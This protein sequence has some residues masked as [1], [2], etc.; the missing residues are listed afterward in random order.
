MTT[1]TRTEQITV[2]DAPDTGPFTAHLALPAS[3]RGPGLVLIQEIFGVNRYIR[4]VADRLAALGYVVLAPDMF[5]R[6]EPGVA[7]DGTDEDA[8]VTA[9]GYA[10]RFDAAA[11]VVDLGAALDH[12]RV[13]PEC[14]G[15]VGVIGFCFGGTFAYLAAAHLDPAV[16]VSYYGSGV[17][18]ALDLLERVRGPILFHFGDEDPYL[19]NADVDRLREASAGMDNVEI[20]VQ[21]GAGHA[22]D[23]GFNPNFS[24]PTAAAAAW[25][26]TV[27]FLDEH[28]GGRP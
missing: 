26:R 24:D 21:A 25:E 3:G 10:G 19:P 4:D 12:L 14:D 7:I 6:L 20:I 11:G 23:N 5:W 22:F 8:L 27:A 18:G 17:G 9:M 28:L 15:P 2:A 16:T 1:A 13:L